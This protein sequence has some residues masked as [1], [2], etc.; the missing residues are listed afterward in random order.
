MQAGRQEQQGFRVLAVPQGRKGMKEG[1][2][3]SV[4]GSY[5]KWDM[6]T[7]GSQ[8]VSESLIDERTDK[9][10]V[11]EL[12]EMADDLFPFFIIKK[13]CHYIVYQ[14]FE[15]GSLRIVIHGGPENRTNDRLRFCAWLLLLLTAKHQSWLQMMMWCLKSVAEIIL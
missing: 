1:R 14:F 11:G 12:Y 4:L 2:K 13:N 10:P 8:K 5:Q 9:E 7:G 6:I 3:E 15:G